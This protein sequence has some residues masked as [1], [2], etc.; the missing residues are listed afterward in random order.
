MTR[1]ASNPSPFPPKSPAAQ[2]SPASGDASRADLEGPAGLRLAYLTTEYPKV[3]HTFI[4]REIVELERRGHSVMRLAIRDS[5]GAV[6]DAA[7]RAE[8]EKT[9]HCLS[10]PKWRLFWDAAVVKVRHPLRWLSAV[11]AMFA[12]ARRS[13]RGLLRHVAYLVEAASLLRQVQRAG[14]EHVHVHFGTNAAAVARLMR[15][16]GGPSYSI[17]VHGPDE[18]DAPVGLSLRDK[19]R[20]AAFVVA[21]S[22]FCSAQIRRWADIS[23][24]KKIHVV[25]CTVDEK[26]LQDA[27]PVAGRSTMLVCVGRLSAQK[28]QLL[29][30]EA[31]GRLVREGVD[32]RLVLAGDGEMRQAVEQRIAE[33]ALEDR[34]KITGWIDETQVRRYLLDSRALVL[35]S[36][37]EGLP[38]VIMEAFAL[39]RPVVSTSIAGIPELLRHGENGWVVPA[40]NVEALVEALRQLM[41]TPV[42][43]L[44]TMGLAGQQRVRLRHT[45]NTE[46][47][48]LEILFERTAAERRAR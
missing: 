20:E 6:A 4:R 27:Q 1:S 15:R 43:R 3:S 29:L 7:D 47:T 19:V 42:E 9:F 11:S 23:D 12:M 26:F 39:G 21:I 35:P 18:F 22:D 13:D 25:R 32:L 46:V 5:G 37:A 24:W 10:Q 30:V 28:A 2:T 17:T 41:E 36:F 16:L 45:A 48:R 8:A 38:V 14:I 40:G 34:V 31:M 44:T 33:L